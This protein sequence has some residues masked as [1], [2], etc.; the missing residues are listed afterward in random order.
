MILIK[1]T[2]IIGYL[3][4]DLSLLKDAFVVLGQLLTSALLIIFTL[5]LLD[6]L[7]DLLNVVL[8]DICLNK[9]LIT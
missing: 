6:I 2:V 1:F 9:M 8:I 7:G 3:I 5:N 4:I